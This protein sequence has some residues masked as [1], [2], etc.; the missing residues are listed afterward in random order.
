[1]LT[2][3]P[4]LYTDF[5]MYNFEPLTCCNYVALRHIFLLNEGKTYSIFFV[6]S[7]PDN[8]FECNTSW[9][10]NSTLIEVNTELIQLKWG[11]GHSSP[12]RDNEC[13]FFSCVCVAVQDLLP[14][15]KK[16]WPDLLYPTST[17]FWYSFQMIDLNRRYMFGS[18]M[19]Y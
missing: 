19:L 4:G 3:A 8:G 5:G 16:S 17:K 13:F 15:M 9:H 10:F 7:R 14:D 2:L 11:G 1:M 18:L 6:F 12:Q